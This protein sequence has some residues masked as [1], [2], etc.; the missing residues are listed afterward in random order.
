M[1]GVWLKCRGVTA[2]LE[3]SVMF[4]CSEINQQGFR[5]T[6]LMWKYSSQQL[7][8]ILIRPYMVV[9]LFDSQNL[10]ANT[11]ALHNRVIH[12][13]WYNISTAQLICANL[14]NENA[15][16]CHLRLYCLMCYHACMYS[17]VSC[18][19]SHFRRTEIF[20]FL[21]S[22]WHEVLALIKCVACS[23]DKFVFF[24]CSCGQEI[25]CE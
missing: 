7:P 4:G 21:K 23:D 20:C 9:L 15:S 25:L 1:L 13:V 16:F 5:Y 19:Q 3:T 18:M 22:V 8:I 10:V 12:S 2:H 14:Q 6:S 17:F 24:F 11:A